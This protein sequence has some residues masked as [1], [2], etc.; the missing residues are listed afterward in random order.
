MGPTPVCGISHEKP[1]SSASNNALMCLLSQF[2]RNAP[3]EP[4]T[5]MARKESEIKAILAA[6]TTSGSVVTDR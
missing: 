6:R 1:L 5:D 4:D 2:G 3:V